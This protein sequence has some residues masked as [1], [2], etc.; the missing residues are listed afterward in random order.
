MTY[1]KEKTLI[2][3]LLWVQKWFPRRLSTH[4]ILWIYYR[5]SLEKKLNMEWG[6]GSKLEP[7]RACHGLYRRVSKEECT[8]SHLD[9]ALVLPHPLAN[10]L[11]LFLL[12]LLEL[13]RES[14]YQ[15]MGWIELANSRWV[16]A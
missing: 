11:S 3:F 9:L 12:C 16:T 13:S 2:S 4:R 14:T 7:S 1:S 10:G 6:L 15:S 8:V 5:D